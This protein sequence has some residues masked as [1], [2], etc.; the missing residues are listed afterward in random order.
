MQ[1]RIHYT[2]Q[3]GTEDS[4]V[5]TGETIEEIQLAA[6]DALVARGGV[7]PWSEQIA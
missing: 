5:V 6:Q 3:D 4:S 1:F 2:L 7:D